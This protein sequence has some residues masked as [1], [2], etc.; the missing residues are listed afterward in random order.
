MGKHSRSKGKRGERKARELL[1]DKDWNI[2]ANTADGEECEDIIAMCPNDRLYSIEVKNRKAIDV[3]A[4]KK[5]ASN[6][7]KKKELLWMIMAKIEG[8]R[9]WLIWRQGER[10]IVW[11]EKEGSNVL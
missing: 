4:F 8:S 9:S 7:A 11:H 2:L 3:T 6:N 5:Q 10:P 1:S